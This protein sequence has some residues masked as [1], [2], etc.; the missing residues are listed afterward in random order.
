MGSIHR[1]KALDSDNGGR[2]KTVYAEFRN[3]ALNVSTPVSAVITLNTET[4]ATPSTTT[5]TTTTTPAITVAPNLTLPYAN[6]T[7]PEE[8]A[9]NRT[10]LISYIITLMQS[11]Q[12]KSVAAPATTVS[13]IPA[14]FQFAATLKQ[15]M[16][17]NDVK[18]L[19]TFLNS[20]PSTSIGNFGSETTYFG[21]LTKA[22]VGK[23]QIKY[24]L[25][26]GASD[27]GYGLVGPK[28]R[29]KI[30]SLLGL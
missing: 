20:D 11:M 25:V 5:T 17:S 1:F 22:A 23:F 7:T 13:G 29:A 30:N 16:T 6:A 8:I 10:A 15:G 21:A 19:Q 18:Y 14:G 28:T 12:A 2:T 24:G 4:V 9:A 27:S 3:A 26:T